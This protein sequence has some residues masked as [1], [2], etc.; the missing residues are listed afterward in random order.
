M[1]IHEPQIARSDH[2]VLFLAGNC[3]TNK[4]EH[5]AIVAS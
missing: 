2:Q 4:L 1:K 5:T 3:D